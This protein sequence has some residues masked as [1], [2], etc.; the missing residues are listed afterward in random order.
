MKQVFQKARTHRGIT[1]P[2]SATKYWFE[3]INNNTKITIQER[4]NTGNVVRTN[5][6]NIGDMAEYDSFNLS[7]FGPIDKITEKAVTIKE[8]YGSDRK[9]HRLDL[10][11]FC[12]RNINFNVAKATADNHETMMYI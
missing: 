7:Y 11:K 12:W 3:I 10:Y 5:T 9:V 2:S 4:D 8:R 6:F 1:S